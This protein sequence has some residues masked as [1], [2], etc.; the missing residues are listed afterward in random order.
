MTSDK[1]T[2]QEI[3]DLIKKVKD[4]VDPLPIKTSVRN[5]CKEAY[6][7]DFIS[8][9]GIFTYG[10]DLNTPT[11]LTN[12]R[13]ELRKELKIEHIEILAK[14]IATDIINKRIQ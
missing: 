10:L 8:I 4:R 9:D 1:S 5:I 3:L 13:T 7:I 12:E 6:R 11:I 2:P 14:T